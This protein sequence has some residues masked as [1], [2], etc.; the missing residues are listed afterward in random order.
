MIFP[1]KKSPKNQVIKYSFAFVQFLYLRNRNYNTDIRTSHRGRIDMNRAHEQL[2]RGNNSRYF[3][4]HNM[5][6]ST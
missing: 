5:A 4:P 6:N 1:D 2:P 3:Y